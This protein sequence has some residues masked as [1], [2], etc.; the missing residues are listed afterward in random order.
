MPAPAA[1]VMGASIEADGGAAAQGDAG[2]QRSRTADGCSCSVAHSSR[3]AES[4]LALL[5][6]CV[7]ALHRRARSRARPGLVDS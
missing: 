1:R 2:A 6:A 7:V 3:R 4:A 5:I